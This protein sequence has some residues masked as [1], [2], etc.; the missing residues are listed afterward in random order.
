ML[1]AYEMLMILHSLKL[2]IIVPMYNAGLYLQGCVHSLL[3]QDL[4]HSDYEILLVNDGSTDDTLWIAEKLSVGAPNIK[5]LSQENRGQSS[6][7]NLGFEE[8]VGEYVWFVDSDDVIAKD[9][10]GTLLQIL[11]THNLEIITFDIVR[12]RA[13]ADLSCFVFRP[14]KELSEVTHGFQYIADHNYN[15]GPW[16]YVIRSEYLRKINLKFIEGRWCEDGMFSISLIS[17]AE[18]IANLPTAIYGYILNPNSNMSS[19]TESHQRKMVEGFLYAVGYFDH[20]ITAMSERAKNAPRFI[21][22]V[23]CRRDSFVFFLLIRLFR[24]RLGYDYSK[25]V[26]GQLIA[27][28]GI[29]LRHFYGEDYPG[30]KYRLLS[31]FFSTRWLFLTFCWISNALKTGRARLDEE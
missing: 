11:K 14:V 10:L 7:R 4:E 6:A 20:F 24:A 26:Y 31:T 2:S 13:R 1:L 8:A 28:G 18:R 5:V 12:A 16:S 9:C 3:D 17:A 27:R 21:K 25:A 15:N 22:R 29:P 30:L 19:K 23:A